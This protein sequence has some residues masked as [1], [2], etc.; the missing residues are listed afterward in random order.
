MIVAPAAAVRSSVWPLIIFTGV[1]WGSGGLASKWLITG[2]VDAFTVTAVPFLVA[3]VIA[4][5][6]ALSAG[7]VRAQAIGAGLLLGALNSAVPALFFN[8]AYE[9]LPAGLVTLILSLGPVVTAATAHFVF[10]DERFSRQKGWGLLLAFGGVGLLVFAPGVIEGASYTGAAW[11]L[12]GACIA[13]STAILSRRFAVRHGARALVGPQLT[14]AGLT[15]LIAGLVVGRSLV[16]DGGF[17]GMDL[18]VLVLIGIAASYGG[19]R[20]IMIAN[21]T[22]TTGQVAMIAYIIPLVGVTGGIVFFDERLTFWVIAGA[23]L[24]LTGVMLGG[25]ASRPG[26]LLRSA[27]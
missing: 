4:W 10:A 5:A 27:G 25:K 8:I 26:R 24:I 18:F 6:V 21:E 22:G 11:T 16:P 19:F 14:A 23:A 15:P 13:G 9:T 1:V 2:G 3:A 12:A 20:A 7:N 17:A